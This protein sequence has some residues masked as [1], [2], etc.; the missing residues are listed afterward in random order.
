MS[1]EQGYKLGQN[2]VIDLWPVKFYQRSLLV[3]EE[4][5]KALLKIIQDL[6]KFNHNV[7][8]EYR[9]QNILNIDTHSV[10]WLRYEVNYSV[11]DY[12]KAI[13]SIIL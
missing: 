1:S 5:N 12:F 4:P 10:N 8:L 7:S 9:D 13:V 6:D 11:I 3:M 2:N